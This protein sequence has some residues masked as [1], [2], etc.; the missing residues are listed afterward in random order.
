MD[1][2]S[3]QIWTIIA[4][5]GIGTFLIR[6]SFL[7]IIGDRELPEW[8]LRH[9]RYTPVSVLPALIA[10]LV[11]W[12]EATGGQPDLARILAAAVTLLLGVTTKNVLAAIF[13]GAGTLYLGLYLL[14]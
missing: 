5:L 1:M 4:L 8:V 9:L 10:P 3:T 6:F 12:P 7:G 2:S 14:G 11:L 13:G